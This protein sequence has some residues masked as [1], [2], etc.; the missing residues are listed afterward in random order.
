M[1]ELEI[2]QSL[3]YGG[4]GYNVEFKVRIPFTVVL[5]EVI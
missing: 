1:L 5:C 4:E 2:I 3:I